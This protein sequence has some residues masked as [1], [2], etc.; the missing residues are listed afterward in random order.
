MPCIFCDIAKKEKEADIIDED[1][2]M[3]VFK[4]VNPKASV[5]LLI[6]PREH[7]HSI[8]ELKDDESMLV[9]KMIVKAR[10]IAEK[11][12]LEGYKLLFN[13]G[14]KGGQLVDHLHLHLLGGWDKMQNSK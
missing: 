10:R 7:I 11:Y 3:V 14:K 12:N 4:D 8:K 13:V 9:G 6:V 5:H 2:L 1:A